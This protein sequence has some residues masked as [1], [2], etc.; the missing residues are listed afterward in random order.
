SRASHCRCSPVETRG[1]YSGVSRAV[2]VC[3]FSRTRVVLWWFRT[4]GGAASSGNGGC[5]GLP[6][7]S[8]VLLRRR[9]VVFRRELRQCFVFTPG[10]LG[11]V[12]SGRSARSCEFLCHPNHH[13][14][15]R[16]AQ[17]R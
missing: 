12:R 11:L 3:V 6:K 5:A 2:R 10:L 15:Y 16:H 8:S 14:D 7:L 9:V 13:V 4:T 1:L 17:G